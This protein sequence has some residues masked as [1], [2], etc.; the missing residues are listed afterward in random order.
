M[1]P[2]RKFRDPCTLAGD[3]S[4]LPNQVLEAQVLRLGPLFWESIERGLIPCDAATGAMGIATCCSGTESPVI[5]LQMISE[6][7]KAEGV[8]FKLDHRMSCEIEAFKAAYITRNF[9]S[10]TV[11]NDVSDLAVGARPGGVAPTS[12]GGKVAVPHAGIYFIF[13]APM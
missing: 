11:F 6:R 2:L 8:E 10:T 5:G 1:Q 4:T 3:L 7:A 9:P 13:Y 12:F